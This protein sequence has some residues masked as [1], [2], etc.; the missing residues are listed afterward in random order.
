MSTLT[1][2]INDQFE[3][4][5]TDA[6]RAAQVSKSEWVRRAVLAYSKQP[7]TKKK[8]VSAYEMGKEFCG[9]YKDA[10]PDLASNPRHM[11]D[12]GKV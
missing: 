2:K 1:L 9:I 3:T 8:F 7:A 4:L 12:Y 11:D 6:A 10:P 5:I